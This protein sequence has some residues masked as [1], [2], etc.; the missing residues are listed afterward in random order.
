MGRL[1]VLTGGPDYAHDFSATSAALVELL[2]ASGH[3]VELADHPDDAADRLGRGDHD[4]LVVNALRWRMLGDRYDEWRTEWGYSTPLATR[5]TIDGYVAAGG[6]LVGVHTASVCFDDW[7]EWRDV[8]GGA[9]SWGR[10]SHPAPAPVRPAVVASHPVVDGLG[11]RSG[12]SEAADR[13]DELALVD[14]VYGDLDL[15]EGIEVLVTAL[16]HAAD[17]PQPVVWAHRHGDGRVVYDAF[18]HDVTSLCVPAHV[19]LLQQAAA[20]VIGDAA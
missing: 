20:W 19:R 2:G 5:R 13:A 18:G 3:D 14:E 7:P 1:L 8:L 15:A 16:R 17:E 4:A 10:S 9:W 6:G 11:G 12:R